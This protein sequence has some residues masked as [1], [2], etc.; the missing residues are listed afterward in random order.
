MKKLL[1]LLGSVAI[2]GS[3]AA[4]AVACETRPF[5]VRV[6][7][8]AD[9]TPES[10]DVMVGDQPSVELSREQL[11]EELDKKEK[12]LKQKLGEASRKYSG[13]TKKAGQGP[14]QDQNLADEID[15]AEAEVATISREYTEVANKLKELK[16]LSTET[17][18]AEPGKEKE[19][20]EPG[21]EKEK[22]EPGKEKEK[23][24][25]GKEKEKAEPGKEKE[26][27]EPG[28]EKEKAEP[29]K[30][31]EKAEPGKEKEKA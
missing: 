15:K 16:G 11:I 5:T 22:A 7:G 13:L 9:V 27:A 8:R 26:K 25:P 28:K 29:G 14:I 21:K 23:A 18:K 19:K 3:S 2:V 1:T 6:N 4:V 12:E 10:S 20:A 24:E 17:P 30:E 31:K